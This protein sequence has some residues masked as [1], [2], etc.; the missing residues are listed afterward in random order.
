MPLHGFT[1]MFENIL[2]HKN[3]TFMAGVDY[4]ELPKSSFGHTIFTGP[5]DGF[6]GH[7]FGKLPYRSLRFEHETLNQEKV[8]PAATVNYPSGDIPFTRSPSSSSSPASSTR[9][10]ACAASS[11]RPRATRT[12]RSPT[13]QPGP[14]QEVRGAADAEKDVT[15]LGRLGTYRYMNMDQVVGQALATARRM[16]PVR[17]RPAAPTRVPVS[18][19][20]GA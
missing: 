13:R 2:D 3:I 16:A 17:E 6:Y 10:P 8:L 5:V 1:R 14:V 9:A 11:R 7:R 12:T 20:R 15:F 4:D 18:A 19:P